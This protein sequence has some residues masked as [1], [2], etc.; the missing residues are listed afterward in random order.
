MCAYDVPRLGEGPISM[1]SKCSLDSDPILRFLEPH[2]IEYW[3]GAHQIRLDGARLLDDPLL[4]HHRRI[5][6]A[7]GETRGA[8]AK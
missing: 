3:C 7:H 6:A 2:E 4:T 8:S 5:T 1:Q